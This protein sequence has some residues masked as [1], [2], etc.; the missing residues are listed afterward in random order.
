MD[1]PCHRY[2]PPPTS[3][4]SRPVVIFSTNLTTS[5]IYDQLLTV[6]SVNPH[7][8]GSMRISDA[9]TFATRHPPPPHS[10][11]TSQT[12]VYTIPSTSLRRATSDGGGGFGS[13]KIIGHGLPFFLFYCFFSNFFQLMYSHFCQSLVESRQ[14]N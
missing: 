1:D 11:P 9:P 4:P 6:D 5:T 13:G 10:D 14:K 7:A 2:L 8:L 12:H 3:H